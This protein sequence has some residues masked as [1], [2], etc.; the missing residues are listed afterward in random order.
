MRLTEIYLRKREELEAVERALEEAVL[1]DREL[2]EETSLHLLKAGGKRIRPMFVLLSSEFGRGD[3]ERVRAVAVGIE[4]IHMATL[5]H[6]DVIDDA[7]TRRGRETVRSKWDNR[8]AMYTGDYLLAKALSVVTR[9]EDPRVHRI[10]SG[11][12]VRM[13]VGEIEQIRLFF[14]IDQS[15]GDYLRRIRR[16]TALLIAASCGLGAL[17]AHASEEAYRALYAYGAFVGMAFQIRDDVLDLTGSERELGKPPG[18]DLRQGN[19]T[20]PVLYALQREDLRGRLT[21]AVERIRNGPHAAEALQEALAIVRSSG[22]V[23]AAES[24][25]DRYVA[26]A[27][28]ALEGLPDGTTKRDLAEIAK[29]AGRR[30]F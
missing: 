4:L 11:V 2:L 15:V 30:S 9:L 22:G 28:D 8:I 17:A 23:E 21:D 5:V 27:L 1:S 25:A 16:K 14:R 7:E 13:C 3:P 29:F 18:S 26:K 6:D 12:I 20:Y 10:L 19:L 24:L